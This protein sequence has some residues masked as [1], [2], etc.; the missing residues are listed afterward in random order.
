MPLY[1]LNIGSNLGDRITN[2]NKALEAIRQ[3]FGEIKTSS[4]VESD[5]WGFDSAN[6]FFNMGVS[7]NSPL[8]PLDVLKK[9]QDIEKSISIFS[10]RDSEGNYIDREIDIDIMA[11]ENRIIKTDLLKVPH[12]CLTKRLFFLR[13]LAELYP[14]WIHPE[15]GKSVE[16]MIKELIESNESKT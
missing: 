12:I 5:P 11:I 15:N 9:L 6:S 7:F 13:P 10:H 16:I 1:L 8:E 3:V 14:G 4:L 2:L